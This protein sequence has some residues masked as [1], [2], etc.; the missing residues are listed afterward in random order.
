M[1]SATKESS[2]FGG[3]HYPTKDNPKHF[4]HPS[5]DVCSLIARGEASAEFGCPD[6]AK[7][8]VPYCPCQHELGSYVCEFAV[9]K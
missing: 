9:K 2:N 3:I 7:V 4:E 1:A 5:P 6:F 8:G